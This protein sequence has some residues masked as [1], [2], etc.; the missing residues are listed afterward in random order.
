MSKYLF[1]D[2]LV[3]ISILANKGILD[4]ARIYFWIN[5]TFY[6]L[7]HGNYFKNIEINMLFGSLFLKMLCKNYLSQQKFET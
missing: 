7:M 5:E 3:N 4:N 2:I 6:I 1:A